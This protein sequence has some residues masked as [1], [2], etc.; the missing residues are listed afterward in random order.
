MENPRK[1]GLPPYKTAVVHGGPGAQGGMAEVARRLSSSAG[2]LEP[3]Q[4]ECS[5]EGEINELHGIIMAA[6]EPPVILIGHSWGAWLSIL[7]AARYPDAISRVIL[8][9]SA[10]FE[11]Q[12]AASIQKRRIER[13]SA[14]E[15]A[16][17][18][19]IM[20]KLSLP[21]TAEDQGLSQRL[22]GL[23]LKCDC[24]EIGEKASFYGNG[25][26]V[27]SRVF[28]GVWSKAAELRSNGSLLKT[29]AQLRCPVLAIHGDHDPHPAEGVEI[30]LGR[31]IQDF[32]FI[33]L[34]RCGHYPWLEKYA[35]EKFY[36]IL[37]SEI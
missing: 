3:I 18:N 24:Y 30:P 32:R 35:S 25:I 37:R 36:E 19:L 26:R 9:A 16:E 4:T 23:L 14:E 10:P 8:V 29:A 21:G 27:D 31:V 22:H 20:R 5:V 17:F 2:I 7:T 15:Q 34:E 33:L 13:L 12:Y 6:G 11:D 1:Y 28:N